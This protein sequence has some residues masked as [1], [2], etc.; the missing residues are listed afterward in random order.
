MFPQK[1]A[2]EAPEVDALSYGV[3]VQETVARID[4]GEPQPLG[5]LAHDDVVQPFRC[6]DD[7]GHSEPVHRHRSAGKIIVTWTALDR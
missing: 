4:C 5:L 3:T 2:H 6:T 7:R 1:T